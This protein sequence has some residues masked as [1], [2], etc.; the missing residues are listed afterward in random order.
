MPSAPGRDGGLAVGCDGHVA[1]PAFVPQQLVQLLPG[2]HVPDAGG[3][4]VAGGDEPLAVGR[5]GQGAEGV[6]VAGQGAH[7]AA[8]GGV[9]EA[10]VVVAP[11]GAAG[12]QLAVGGEGDGTDRPAVAQARRAEAV[13]G[14]GR[15][16]VALGVGVGTSL[17]AGGRRRLGFGGGRLGRRR[18]EEAGAEASDPQQEQRQPRGAKFQRHRTAE[19]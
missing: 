10:D 17:A 19:Q 11:V 2:P 14:A 18:A 13:D 16:R 1:H 8:G 4:V 15:E 6:S 7:L 12:R 5:E 3:A 9:P